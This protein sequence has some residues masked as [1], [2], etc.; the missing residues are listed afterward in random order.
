MFYDIIF[1]IY[2]CMFPSHKYLGS[3]IGWVGGGPT[4]GGVCGC[5]VPP[6][7]VPRQSACKARSEHTTERIHSERI[8]RSAGKRE[9][10]NI[11]AQIGIKQYHETN[12]IGMISALYKHA[13]S[14]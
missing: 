6:G 14:L 5:G 4:Q 10:L 1:Y 3:S 13:N 11:H 12:K 8:S 7:V 9:A 2:V